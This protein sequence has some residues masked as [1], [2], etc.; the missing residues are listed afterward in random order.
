MVALDALVVTTALEHDPARPRRLDRGAGVDRQ[1]LQPELRRAAADGR[2]ARR[3]LRAPAHVRCR[4]WDCSWRSAAC[5]L[6]SSVGWLIAA[7][8]VQG[9]GAALVMPLAMALLS[10]AFPR[11]ERGR[12][13]WASSAASP[14]RPDRRTGGGR[15][16]RRRASPGS[17][18]SGSICRSASSSFRWC[19]RRIRRELRRRAPR[20]TSRALRW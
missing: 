1:R 11:E 5:A 15:R 18:S 6:A 19:S 2:R 20:S 12:G 10:A 3:P 13:A 16:D 9:A 17:G 4:P 14:A 7:R 8:A